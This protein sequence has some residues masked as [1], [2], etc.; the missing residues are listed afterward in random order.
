MELCRAL[1]TDLPQVKKL[2]M[3]I[4]KDNE[5]F[6][7]FALS[8]C[9]CEDI[10]LIKENG[11]IAAMAM[12]AADV[13][14]CGKKG[15]YL[16]G[17]CTA[18][19]YRGRGFAKQII[20]YICKNKFENGYD[21]AITQPAS[22]SLFDFYEKLGF[23]KKTYLRKFTVNIKR[24]IWS[25]AEF[26]TVT[27]SKFRQIRDKFSTDNIVHFTDKGYVKFTQYIYSEGGSTA[28]TDKGYCIYFEEKDRL[29]VRELFSKETVYAMELLQAIRERTGKETADI[30]LSENSE[31]FLGEGRLYPHA[32]LK[33]LDKSVYTNL[34][35]D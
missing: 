2:W 20:E 13:E 34:M 24:N 3:D 30:E 31:L 12:A 28:V 17:V 15:F 22:E 1:Q 33:N 7:D 35:F 6:T 27:A 21:F 19:K 16:Y 9:P 29:K 26:D 8:L 18:E 32:V 11:E 4:F 5:N 14:V 25:T 23:D 10:C